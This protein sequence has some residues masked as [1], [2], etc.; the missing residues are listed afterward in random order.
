MTTTI[1]KVS[2][3]TPQRDAVARRLRDAG[4]HVVEIDDWAGAAETLRQW[5]AALVCEGAV[6][7]ADPARFAQAV[8]A[9][10]SAGQS[11]PGATA[12]VLRSLSHELRTPLSAMS[13]WL[14]LMESGSLDAAGL[15]RAIGKLRGNIEDQVRTIDRYLGTQDQEGRR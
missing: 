10:A 8:S 2:R 1:L 14:H 6:V 3:D 12:E 15:K 9:F 11:A 4:V 13:G 5:D 7:D